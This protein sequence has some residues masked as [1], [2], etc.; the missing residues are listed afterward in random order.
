M[1][2][3]RILEWYIKYQDLLEISQTLMQTETDKIRDTQ[4][5]INSLIGY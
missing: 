5:T 3:L 4:I 1:E 2:W